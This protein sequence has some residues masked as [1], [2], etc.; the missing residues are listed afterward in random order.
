MRP[1]G[2]KR[3]EVERDKLRDRLKGRAAALNNPA[4]YLSG[5]HQL[6][7]D[8]CG[9]QPLSSGVRGGESIIPSDDNRMDTYFGHWNVDVI[10][11]P[12]GDE[13][14][15]DKKCPNQLRGS[16]ERYSASGGY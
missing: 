13:R 5:R 1:F 9:Y 8:E 15:G 16:G 14:A 2:S 3:P 12:M 11:F 7:A 6:S 4:G 10:L